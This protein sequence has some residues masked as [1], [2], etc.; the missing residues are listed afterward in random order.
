VS[1][2]TELLPKG[3]HTV[4]AT[5]KTYVYAWRGGPRI[6]AEPGT[7]AFLTE[8]SAARAGGGAETAKATI[9]T[10]IADY[11]R[12][13]AWTEVIGEATRKL[14]APW[15]DRIREKFGKTPV[16]DFD[17]PLMVVAVRKWRD[18]YRAK[19][20]AAD[21]GL[22][23]LSR[24][25]SFAASEGVLVNNPCAKVAPISGTNRAEVI[26]EPPHLE[27]LR[28]GG[29]DPTKA[30]S[31]DM[32][33]VVILAALTG[34][35]QSD[36]VRLCWSHIHADGTHLEITA[37]KSRVTRG[38]QRA[39]ARRTYLVPMYPALEAFLATIPRRSPVIL[40]T[41]KGKPWNGKSLAV[42]FSTAK[43]EIGGLDHLHFHDLRG[44]AATMYAQADFKPEEIAE[45]LAWE[46]E[47]VRKIIRR[48]VSR[49]ALM[50]ARIAKLSNAKGT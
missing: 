25:L 31:E 21:F 23:V 30:L 27:L 47:K 32:M 1:K 42:M 3:I 5:G 44:T 26:W 48:Y 6:K 49:N 17:R 22:G 50:R 7:D 28:T 37:D 13:P 15:L 14:Y 2:K 8:L 12:D 29:G 43:N 39:E 38:G 34:L 10:L 36:L 33:R 18:S 41:A 4:R 46:P 35:R 16:K 40:T 19:P 24:L 45:T 11:K 20:A 9:T